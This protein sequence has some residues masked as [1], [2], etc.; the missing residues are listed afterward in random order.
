VLGPTGVGKT[1]V[2]V[3]LARF[4][5]T[6][7]ISCDSMQV[8]E[9]FPVLTNQPNDP[10]D[11][12]DLHELM[13]VVDPGRAISAPEYADMARPIIEGELAEL[14]WG[15][16]A[17]GSGLYMRAA[18]AP[19]AAPGAADPEQRS[20]LEDL[21]RREG[22]QTLHAELARL[23]PEA[24]ALIDHRNVRR[25]VRALE[26]ALSSGRKWSGRA[27]LWEPEYYHPSLVIGLWMDRSALAQ[28]ILVRTESMLDAGAVEEVRRFC[29]ER[30][31]EATR[32]GRPGICSAIG[33]EDIWRYLRGEQS[34]EETVERMACATRKYARRQIT[35]LRKVRDAVMIEV[36]G[37]D[38]GEIARY[39]VALAEGV[40]D[41]GEPCT[42]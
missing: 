14:G 42:R 27:D 13:G 18:L 41:S 9:G 10:E 22:S 21:A 33:Y 4:L 38:A 40:S 11:R 12:C 19:L 31:E 6:R 25:V 37:Q 5:G 20:R 23:D 36:K 35:W 30:G 29:E 32:P 8:Y 3:E 34:R 17:G 2:A 15:L 26:G 7:I 39:I 24:A 16:L 1:A 28:R